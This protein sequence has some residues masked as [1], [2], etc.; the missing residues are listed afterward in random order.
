MDEVRLTEIG[1]L[2]SLAPSLAVTLL[3]KAS[4]RQRRLF[5]CA[6]VRLVWEHVEEPAC[7]RAVEV[8]EAHCDR[9][10]TRTA[11]A[12][13]YETACSVPNEDV[14][15]PNYWAQY[16]AMFVASTHLK[17]AARWAC[18]CV[19]RS[20]A[21]AI[22]PDALS[23]LDGTVAVAQANREVRA[24]LHDVFGNPFRSVAFDRRWRTADT[25]GLARAIYE[26]QAY[27]LFP[28][29]RDAL[30]D[31]GCEHEQVLTHTRRRKHVRGCWLVDW[32]LDKS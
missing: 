14:S 25:V 13:A 10:A 28:L 23:H 27:H 12:A 19:I 1:W 6:C 20:R 32:I 11:P 26:D 2:R 3:P 24:I 15:P 21:V 4:R 30:M 16:A 22:Y 9:A 8:A 7:R 29:L 5:A 17:L 31:T 18:E